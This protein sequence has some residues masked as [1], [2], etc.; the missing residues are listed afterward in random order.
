[1][2]PWEM[3]SASSRLASLEDLCAP[4]SLSIPLSDFERMGGSAAG[5]ISALQDEE[6][7]VHELDDATFY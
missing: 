6:N 3:L 4:P 2:T 5:T 1:M 7:F